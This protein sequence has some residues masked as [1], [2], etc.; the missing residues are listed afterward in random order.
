MPPAKQKRDGADDPETAI[1]DS[2]PNRNTAYGAGDEGEWNNSRA[3][4]KAK[5]DDPLVTN[6]I[7]VWTEECNGYDKVRKR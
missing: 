1:D 7:A 3:G 4:D 2:P 6:R 5:G